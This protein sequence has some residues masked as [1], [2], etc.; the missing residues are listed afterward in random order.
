MSRALMLQCGKGAGFVEKSFYYRVLDRDVHYLKESL[1]ILSIP[2]WIEP[3]SDSLPLRDD[4]VAFVFPDVHVRVY[5]FIQKL[6]N[7]HGMRYPV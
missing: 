3:A 2:Y 7:G 1:D 5:N 6:F 4:E